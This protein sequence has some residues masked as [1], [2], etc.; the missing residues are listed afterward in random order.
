MLLATLLVVATLIGCVERR[1]RLE[2]DPPGALIF[3]NGEEVARTP[4]VVPLAWYGRYD[5]VARKAGYETVQADRWVVAPW[6]G[7][8]PLDLLAE[9]MPFRITHEPTLRVELRPVEAVETGL[10]ERA[11][12]LRESQVE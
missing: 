10:I 11:E 6:W 7:W 4:A 12:E 1:L 2:S 5:V 9:L 3:L 8:F